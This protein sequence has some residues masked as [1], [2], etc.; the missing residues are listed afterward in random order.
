MG[1]FHDHSASSPNGVN[2]MKIEPRQTYDWLTRPYGRVFNNLGIPDTA[3]GRLEI[4]GITGE[5]LMAAAAAAGGLL[6]GRTLVLSVVENDFAG[7]TPATRYAC[8][9][10][11]LTNCSPFP[12]GSRRLRRGS[13]S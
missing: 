12:A 2:D 5:K 8:W 10:G 13:R 11:D 9:V 6:A 7:L 3:Q 4:A 1:R